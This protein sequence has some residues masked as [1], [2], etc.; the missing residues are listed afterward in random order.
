MLKTLLNKILVIII[1]ILIS[2][3][4]MYKD[5]QLKELEYK[6]DLLVKQIESLQKT[7]ND[8]IRLKELNATVKDYI[9][10]NKNDSKNIIQDFKAIDNYY[11]SFTNAK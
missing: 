9:F 1:I 11:N 5:K 6:N 2:T 3:L 8:N 7:Y 10:N 4:Y